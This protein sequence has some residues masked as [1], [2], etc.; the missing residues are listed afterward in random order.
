MKNARKSLTVLLVSFVAVLAAPDRSQGGSIS[1]VVY[2]NSFEQT[3]YLPQF[4]PSLGPLTGISYAG[5]VGAGSELEFYQPQS[6]V[7]YSVYMQLLLIG[8]GISSFGADSTIDLPVQSGTQYYNSPAEGGY[9]TPDMV[10]ISGS[11]DVASYFYGTG[12]INVQ[13]GAFFD[14]DVPFSGR[15]S[16]SGTM[17]FTYTYGVP[18]PP[19]LVL[20]SIAAILPLSLIA[21]KRLIKRAGRD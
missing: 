10:D 8:P 12:G 11:L 5:S 21:W 15:E 20:A 16:A 19:G 3:G 4:D 13:I 14:L 9:I 6:S 18:E 7:T 2:L 1:Y 17:T